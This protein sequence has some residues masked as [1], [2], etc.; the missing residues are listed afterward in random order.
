MERVKVLM[1]SAVA[2][3]VIIAWPSQAQS[4]EGTGSVLL[5]E[6]IVTAQRR[7]QRLED[8]AASINVLAGDTVGRRGLREASDLGGLVPNFRMEGSFGNS[9]NP[10]ITIRGVGLE[11]F[12]DNNSS[13]AGVY[14]D[15]VYLVAPPML[16]FGLFDLDRVEILKGPQGTLYG[17]NTTAGALNF[18]SRRPSEKTEGYVRVGY[19]SYERRTIEAALGGAISD[20]LTARVAG[21]GDRGGGPTTNRFD[22]SRNG[23][24]NFTA[25]RLLVE[26]DGGGDLTAL[27]K[28]HG[29]RD[30]SEIGQYQHVGLLS[31]PTSFQFC[32]A[33]LAGSTDPV[34][35]VDPFGYSDGDGDRY[36]GA[37]NRTGRLDYD[38]S[39]ASLNL[40][41]VL[42]D[43]VSLSAISALEKFDGIRLEDSDASPNRFLEIDYGVDVAQYSQELRLNGVSG[44]LDW[45]AGAY[46]STDTIRASNL[47]DVFRDFRP[48]TGFAPDAGVFL[49]RNT[50]RQETD[51]W[52]A[53]GHGFWE[54]DEDWT[55]EGGLRLAREDRGFRTVTV[56]QE[57]GADLAAAGLGPDGLLLDKRLS[58]GT[59]NVLWSTGVSFRPDQSILA[60]AKAGNGFKSGGFNGGIPFTPDEVVP[61]DEESLLAYEVGIKGE[62]EILPIRYDLVGFYYDYT[63]LQV[64]TVAD[65]GAAVPVQILTNAADSEIYG[66]EASL[67]ANPLHG[68]ELAGA[69]GLLNAKYLD[70]NIGGRDVSGQTL[71]N[72]PKLTANIDVSYRGEIG[73]LA[74]T[75]AVNAAYQTGETLDRFATGSGRT[76]SI[77]EDGYWLV[78]TTLTLAMLDNMA[79]L[80]LF[81]KNLF[82]SQPLISVVPLPDFGFHEYTYGAPRRI[83]VSL[84]LYL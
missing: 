41:W 9:S 72:S 29:A 14:V 76:A 42:S 12:N 78:D 13:P 36:D 18:V 22:G 5:E 7:E 84:S 2:A 21:T 73:Q 54:L 45:V 57:S 82:D 37:Y 50:Y 79:E 67:R 71:S 77:R 66:L 17:R 63:D 59:T 64:F 38:G 19:G 26:W 83:G 51:V 28:V 40:G 27:V 32:P 30:R 1:A 62:M 81:A 8:V 16:A 70:A 80:S 10:V 60:Y 46:V 31:D 6:I 11:D 74:A 56:Y 20:T 52:A 25:G 39:G 49:A 4:P 35:C 55:L 3:Q 47:Y 44:S 58:I 68:L 75:I 61:F 33:A 48:V 43:D 15:D 69:V 53:F 34:T 23:D 24:R 65:T